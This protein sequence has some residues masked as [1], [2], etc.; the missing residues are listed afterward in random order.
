[1]KK[2]RDEVKILT[3]LCHSYQCPLQHKVQQNNCQVQEGSTQPCYGLEKCRGPNGA[4]STFG[5]I[6]PLIPSSSSLDQTAQHSAEPDHRDPHNH[7]RSNTAHKAWE[8]DAGVSYFHPSHG[9]SLSTRA[10]STTAKA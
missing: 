7:R 6:L 4:Y 5:L 2:L 8:E 9:K 3:Y 1:M 10:I